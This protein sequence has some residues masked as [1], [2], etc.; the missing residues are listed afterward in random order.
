[1]SKP[2]RNQSKNIVISTQ[3]FLPVLG[4]MENLMGNL[5]KN[6]HKKKYNIF[7]FADGKNS[8]H[9]KS[10]CAIYSVPERFINEKGANSVIS[11]ISCWRH[12]FS[13]PL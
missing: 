6:L 4:G 7:V 9:E 10:A 3:C 2:K 13:V 12:I 11:L 1:M 5:A 8:A